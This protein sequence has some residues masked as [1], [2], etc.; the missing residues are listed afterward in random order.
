M[1]GNWL[2]GVV[3]YGGAQHKKQQFLMHGLNEARTATCAVLVNADNIIVQNA[4]GTAPVSGVA[5]CLIFNR[6]LVLMERD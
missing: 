6:T 5:M 2:E 3:T 4:P 1:W